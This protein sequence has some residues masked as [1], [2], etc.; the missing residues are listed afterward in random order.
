[1]T[2]S[3]P[4]NKKLLASLAGVVHDTP[5]I[6]LMRQAGRYLPEYRA[7][8]ARAGGFLELCLTPALAAEVTLQPVRRFGFDGAILFS[9]ILVV[10]HGLTQRVGFRDGEGPVLDALSSAQELARL[11]LS[12]FAERVTAVGETVRQV[13]AVLPGDVSLIGFAGS[14]WTV[15]TYMVEGGSSRDFARVKTWL[16]RDRKGFGALIDLLVDATVA[17]LDLQI[18]AGAE[19]VQ[20]FESWAGALTAAALER[21][22]VTPNATIVNRLK[23]RHPQVPVILFPRG[24]GASYPA[25]GEGV[26]VAGI[27]L[28][29]TVPL[30]WA[31]RTLQPHHTLQGNLD[32]RVLVTGGV[33][34]ADEIR[35]IRAALG[36]GPFIFNLG[37]GVLPDTPPEHVAELVRQVRT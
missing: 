6:W 7:V 15:A 33:A 31:R 18:E 37:H 30:D 10:P 13:H 1:M 23:Q 28:D 11:K 12:G 21:W 8:R 4:G 17:Y 20:L 19:V 3:P 14:P 36:Q 24:A 34:L 9:D 5:P 16:Y 2:T 32:P 25:V 27:G 26:A 22:V 35:R 29:T